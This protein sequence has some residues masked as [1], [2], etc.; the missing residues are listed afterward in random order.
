SRAVV[1]ADPTPFGLWSD[2]PAGEFQSMRHVSAEEMLNGG[3]GTNGTW[4]DKEGRFELEGLL[5]RV[6]RVRAIDHALA[7]GEE[8]SVHAGS[9]G[10]ELSI[11]TEPTSRVAGRVVS[12][13]GDPIPNVLVWRVREREGLEWMDVPHIGKGVQVRTDEEGRF[14]FRSLAWRGPG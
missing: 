10:V 7:L 11:A 12:L 13:G 8:R 14:E 9:R 4:T 6:Y 2:L 3:W 1:W 5:D